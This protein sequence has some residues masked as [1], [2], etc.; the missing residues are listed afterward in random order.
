MG[1]RWWWL[2][3]PLVLLPKCYC[4]M[5]KI[6]GIGQ[7]F[8][9]TRLV[10]NRLWLWWILNQGKKGLMRYS[11]WV[12]YRLNGWNVLKQT[13]IC[14]CH[15]SAHLI[16]WNCDR[17]DRRQENQANHGRPIYNQIS[18]S[19]LVRLSVCNCILL[20]DGTIIENKKQKQNSCKGFKWVK[21]MSAQ[22]N[23]WYVSGKNS[24]L[25]QRSHYPM[26][27]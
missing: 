17:L 9:S 20:Y 10:V 15:L 25:I 11:C 24:Q 16:D 12:L 14:P 8:F 6:W 26:K 18:V 5:W 1:F 3:C 21:G 4:S 13:V 2:R 27:W 7:C 19:D 23:I 22:I